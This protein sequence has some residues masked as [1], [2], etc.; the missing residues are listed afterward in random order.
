MDVE[1]S[2]V[3]EKLKIRLPYVR[4]D[5]ND[6]RMAHDFLTRLAADGKKCLQEK[7]DK[8]FVCHTDAL[9]ALD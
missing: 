8:E 5:K 6:K 1:L 7:L 3:A 9:D 4:G 2:L